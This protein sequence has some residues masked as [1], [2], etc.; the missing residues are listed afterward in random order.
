M[1]LDSLSEENALMGKKLKN[2]EKNFFD[3]HSRSLVALDWL[4]DLIMW[5]A[6]NQ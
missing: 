2:A 6:R 3:N 5:L 4:V 1:A